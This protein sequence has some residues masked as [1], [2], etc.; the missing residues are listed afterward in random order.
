[1]Y[2]KRLTTFYALH[3]LRPGTTVRAEVDADGQFHSL[4]YLIG[5]DKSVSFTRSG[6]DIRVSEDQAHYEVVPVARSGIIRSSLFAAADDANMPDSVAIQMADIFG[7]DIDFNRDLRK[8][9][10][11]SVVYEMMY[12]DGLPVR[13]GRVLAAEFVNKGKAFRAVFF[14]TSDSGQG[15]YYA[16]DGKSLRKAFLRS[17]LAFSRVTSGFGRRMHPFLNT[18]RAHTGVD[19][20]APTG[21]AIRA[22]GD[23]VVDF[24]GRKGGYGNV[25]ILR[26]TGQNTTLYGHMNH[27]ARGIHRGVRVAQGETIGAVGSTGWA[28]GPHVHYEFR[29]AGVPRNPLTIALPAAVP[30]PAAQMAAFRAHAADLV[31]QLD[32]L[33]STNVA[34]L[35]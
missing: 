30:V 20:A 31:A 23:G 9:D 14:A 7:G 32:L 5:H 1:V 24:A 27:F 25:V 34:L 17:P 11:F 4:S 6:E 26:H 22:T 10:H 8:D 19:Y 12:R 28:T 2:S 16:P 29:V 18:W 13:I 15:G 33:S 3:K 21:T 35:Q